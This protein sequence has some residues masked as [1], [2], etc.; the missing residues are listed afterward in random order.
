MIIFSQIIEGNFHRKIL[1]QNMRHAVNRYSQIS[2]P[3]KC[4]RKAQYTPVGTIVWVCFYR[5]NGV[6][7]FFENY[8]LLLTVSQ[9]Y[10][11]SPLTWKI[12]FFVNNGVR[13]VLTFFKYARRFVKISPKKVC[14]IVHM[15]VLISLYHRRYLRWS[16]FK[17]VINSDSVVRTDLG[18]H[19]YR[20]NSV[21]LIIL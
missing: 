17:V 19:R 7:R 1:S 20:K 13:I 12:Q 2:G 18:T 8:N 6:V 10:F 5:D 15:V 4:G 14:Q 3:L 11:I 16:N 21:L 9:I